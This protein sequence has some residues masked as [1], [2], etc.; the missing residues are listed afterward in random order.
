MYNSYNVGS[1]KFEFPYLKNI[2]AYWYPI[3]I[4]KLGEGSF[5]T[6]TILERLCR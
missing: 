5:L 3:E 2:I 6:L 4:D 1:N